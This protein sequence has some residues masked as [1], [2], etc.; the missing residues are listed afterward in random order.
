MKHLILIGLVALA[1]CSSVNNTTQHSYTETQVAPNGVTLLPSANMWVSFEQVANIYDDTMACLGLTAD[2]PDVEFK[3]FTKWHLGGAWA[4]YHP[5]GLVMINIDEKDTSAGFPERAAWTD[6]D[7]LKHEFVHHIL[8]ENGA[9]Y[10][11]GESSEM[12]KKCGIG[13]EV[14]N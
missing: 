11:D 4:L 13:V 10:H 3:S 14:N 6:T 1:G 2:G 12:F 9:P 5:G 7:A 8:H